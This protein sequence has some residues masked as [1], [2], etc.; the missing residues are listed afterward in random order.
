MPNCKCS[1]ALLKSGHLTIAT[2]IDKN[3]KTTQ[4]IAL[5]KLKEGRDGRLLVSPVW[6]AVKF[7]PECGKPLTA[8]E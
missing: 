7:C 5:A 8:L 2:S 1:D 6:W 4:V 3:G